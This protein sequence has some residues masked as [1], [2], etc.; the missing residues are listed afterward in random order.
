MLATSVT[1]SVSGYAD[2]V[3]VIQGTGGRRRRNWDWG[4]YDRAGV[5][6]VLLIADVAVDVAVAALWEFSVETCRRAVSAVCAS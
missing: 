5:D 4:G 1:A 2:L 6:P 3:I